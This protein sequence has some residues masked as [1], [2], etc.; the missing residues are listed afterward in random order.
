MSGRLAVC[1][2]VASMWGCE[3]AVDA[4]TRVLVLAEADVDAAQ[5]EEGGGGVDG[6]AG[7]DE[8]AGP[9]GGT[10]VLASSADALEEVTT[11]APTVPD[12]ASTCMSQATSCQQACAATKSTCIAGCHGKDITT[13]QDQCNHTDMDCNGACSHQCTMCFMQ[14]SCAGSS[15][16]SMPSSSGGG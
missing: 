6:N 8:N 16:C 4:G 2:A 1:V 5:A 13:C 9:D 3:L 14:A 10:D 11:D 7:P 12:C 15:S